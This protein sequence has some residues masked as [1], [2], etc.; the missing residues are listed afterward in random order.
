MQTKNFLTAFTMT[1]IVSLF[2]AGCAAPATLTA[3][4]TQLAATSAPANPAAT[5][6]P[7]SPGS[8]LPSATPE[9][10]P[11]SLEPT[12]EAGADWHLVVIGDSSLW[13]LGEALASQIEKDLGLKVALYDFALPSLSAGSVLEALQTGKSLRYPKLAQLSAVLQEAEVVVMFVNPRD[14]VDP[15]KPLDLEGC[16]LNRPPE[17]CNPESFEKYTVDMKAIWARILELRVGQPAILR[18]TDLY[19]P[20]VSPWKEH[21]VFEA[22]TECWQ[23]MSTAARLAAEAYDIPFLSR[24]EAFNGVDRAEDP[25]EKGFIVSDGEH[26]S[27]LAAQFTAGLLSKMGYEPVS[28]P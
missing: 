18:A 25:R 2:L 14:S 15:A 10:S 19:N 9:P 7:T 16:F 6:I 13:Q 27:E 22:C 1:I 17:S 5:P 26:P 24:Y 11:P 4:E 28:P 8:L 3:T 20:L 23:N 12:Q 21:S